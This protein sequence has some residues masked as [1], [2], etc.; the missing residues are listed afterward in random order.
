[1]RYAERLSPDADIESEIKA[2]VSDF[3]R[4]VVVK[5]G[6]AAGA[7]RTDAPLPERKPE[8]Y[9]P[10]ELAEIYRA[11]PDKYKALM[12]SIRKGLKFPLTG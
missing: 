10:R 2:L 12:Q 11:D 8:E 9:T 3:A 1:L 4:P 6:V 7:A 5:P